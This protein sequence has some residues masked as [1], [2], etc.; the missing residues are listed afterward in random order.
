MQQSNPTSQ[1]FNSAILLNTRKSI[2][3][4]LFQLNFRAKL[5]GT[6]YLED[7]LLLKLVHW[8]NGLK[9]MDVYEA[10]A[11][12]HNTK[13]ANVERAIR[14]TIADCFSN[15]MLINVNKMFDCKVVSN[16]YPPRT[17]DFIADITS[18]VLLN[19]ESAKRLES[20]TNQLYEEYA[21][22]Q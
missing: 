2:R 6:E 7:A 4:L 14:N 20:V 15:G 19:E 17:S 18:L 3:H 5:V 1:L 21:L 13:A 22:A 11:K 9:T 12:L 8:S 16:N 10:V